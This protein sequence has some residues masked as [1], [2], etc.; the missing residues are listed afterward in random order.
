PE[1][2]AVWEHLKLMNAPVLHD[3]EFTIDQK[4][5]HKIAAGGFDPRSR[6]FQTMRKVGIPGVMVT[7]NRM[8]FGVASLLGRLEATANWRAMAKE[9]WWNEPSITPLGKKEQAWLKKAH[10]E[11]KPVLTKPR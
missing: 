10:P 9:L 1:I 3:G 11:F 6:A 4:L 2:D 7:F 5:I 8:S